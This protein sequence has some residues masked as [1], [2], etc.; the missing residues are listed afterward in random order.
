M[1]SVS[2]RPTRI[3]RGSRHQALRYSV[4]AACEYLEQRVLLS[5]V[6]WNTSASGSWDTAANWLATDTSTARVPTAGDNV[7]IN[8]AGVTVTISAGNAESMA[9]LSCADNLQITSGS[10]NITSNSEIDG[11]FGIGGSGV[12]MGGATLTVTGATEWDSAAVTSGTLKN[13]GTLTLGSGSDKALNGATLD[14]TGT[15]VHALGRLIPSNGII[16]NESGG[17]YDFQTDDG[18]VFN[19]GTDTFNNSGTLRKSVGTGTSFVGITFNNAAGAAIN[20]QTGTLSLTAGGT[21]LGGVYT[22][23][24]GAVFDPTGGTTNNFTGTYTGSGAGA[25]NLSSGTLNIAGGATFNF[26]A[27]F[28]QWTGGAIAGG[29]LNNT[30]SITLSGANDKALNGATIENTGTILHVAG[31]LIPSNG[32]INNHV[33]ATYDL[34]SAGG[35]IFNGGTDAFSNSG[36]L[37]KSAGTGNSAFTIVFNNVPGAQVNVL[38]GSISFNAGGTSTGGTFNVSANAVLDLTAGSTNNLTGTYTGSGAGTILLANGVLNIAGGATFNFASGYFQWTGGAI[39]GGT[40]VNANVLTLAS[41]ND[42]ALNGATLDN[43]GTVIHLMGRLIPS[44]GIIMNEAN[45]V[46]DFQNAADASITFNGG[47]DAFNNFGTLRKSSGAGNVTITIVFNNDAAGVIDDRNATTMTFSGGT[48]DAGAKF[49]LAS[50]A[51]IDPTGGGTTNW[52]GTYTS[53]GAGTIL[54]ANGTLNVGNAGATFNFPAGIFQWTGG[55]LTGGGGLL[56]KGI[57]TLN[58]TNDKALNGIVLNNAGTVLHLNGRLLP[59]NGTINN[60]SG[61]LYDLQS[62]GGII[63]NGGTDAFN[64][65][66]IFE[67]SAGTVSSAI[68]VTYNNVPGAQINVLT[69]GI[70]LAGSGSNTG[71]IFNLSAGTTLD[72]TGGNNNN[73][74]G[75]YTGSGAGTVQMASG[76]L[77]VTAGATFNLPARM[78][79]WTGGAIASGTLTNA[80][81]LTLS[82]INDK[83]LNGATLDNTGTIVHL[84]GRLLPSNGTVINEASGLYD[85]QG[86]NSIVFN[87]GTDVVT[88]SGILRKSLGTGTSQITVGVTNSGTIEVDSGTLSLASLTQASSGAIIVRVFN[89][90]GG[91]LSIQSPFALAGTLNVILPTGF[92]PPQGNTYNVVSY[93]SQTGAFSSVNGLTA[94]G[95][96]FTPSVGTTAVTL[97]TTTGSP[98]ASADLTLTSVS[99]NAGTYMAGDTLTLTGTEQNLGTGAAGNYDVEVALSTDQIFGDANNIVLKTIHEI[100]LA[101]EASRP[102]SVPLTIPTAATGGTYYLLAQIDSGQVINQT[103]YTNDLFVS[104]SPNVIVAVPPPPPPVSPPPPP[105]TSPPPAPV[106]TIGALDPTFGVNGLASH[107]VGLTSTAGVVV[108]S[109]GKSVIAGT[110]GTSPSQQFGVTRYNA[111]GSLDTSFGTNGV[112]TSSFGGSDVAS[113]VAY[114]PATGDI[115]VAGTD[116]TASGSRFVLA[117]Y[118]PAGVLDTTFNGTGFVLTSFSTTPGTMSHDTAKA[119]AV[120]SNGSTICVAGSS[121]AAGKGLDFA[122]ASYN[123][124]GS[125]NTRFGGSGMVTLDFA[126]GDDSINAIALQTNGDLV[127]AGSTTNPSN[128]IASIALARFL[129]TGAVDTRFGSKG[130]VVASGRGVAD[131]ASSVAIDRT[132]KIVIGGLSATGSASDGSL[133]SDFVVARYTSAGLLDR[134]FNGGTV[135][136]SFGQPSAVT[137]VLIQGDG[138]IVASGKTVASLTGLDPS[139]LNIA[140]ARYTSA[141]KLDT[142]FNS[143]G[144]AIIGLNGTS[145]TPQA[146]RLAR[147]SASVQPSFIASFKLTQFSITPQDT[148]SSLLAEFNQFQQSS[149]GVVAVTQGG[150]LLDVGNSGANTVEAALVTA[151]IDL[152]AT[153]VAKLPTAALEGA[154]GSLTVKITESGTNAA[155]GTVTIQLFASP[156]GFVDAG[157][158]PFASFPERIINLRQNQSRTFPLRYALPASAGTF[159]V[160]ANVDTGSLAEL[161][162]NNN[163]AASSTAVQVASPFVDLAGSGLTSVGTPAA[164]KFTTI[165]FTVTNNGNILAHSVPVQ[166]L[167]SPDGTVVIGSPLA[168]PTLLLNLPPGVSRKYH[169]TFRVPTTLAANTYVLVAVLDPGNTLSDPTQAD[170]VIVGTTQFTVH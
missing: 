158:T 8:R 142:T 37:E 85:I 151:G 159:F 133:S 114:L 110:A 72:L 75:T 46:Y 97:T 56:N 134:T 132:G 61:G 13:T 136:T 100:G 153:L 41:S 120:A 148:A 117:E 31:R 94:A 71:G 91:Q 48:N 144:M 60:Q 42:K 155:S 20:V 73:F 122:V 58:G 7:V 47:T 43:I 135:I 66:G 45:G 2:H 116:T 76:V 163:A 102:L 29:T 10:L 137:Q 82:G 118:T 143:T 88:N 92:V 70:A 30:A 80:G 89:Q 127:A 96:A 104:A 170:N 165:S 160:V 125:A 81:V 86:D 52:S 161:N 79:Q 168:Q 166:V 12:N 17:T 167:A 1:Q 138:K 54:L 84:N 123:A 157:L 162:A 51:V 49:L 63:F 99:Y 64:N 164:G 16:T 90:G 150:Q 38:T 139:Q 113:A 23:A 103:N 119:L 149:Q 21:S 57:L 107:N 121:D 147:A 50:G 115:L 68:T 27:G 108:Q 24:A 59:S 35:I 169:M 44:N 74:T 39:S 32:T 140:L 5:T 87:G 130:K 105:P 18:I 25:V 33:G 15:V 62:A 55:A 19:G 128:G 28:F 145:A 36:V 83:A 4:R 111:D 22:V 53:T 93:P 77:S 14:N 106:K 101:G 124:D 95:V 154:K 146:A 6:Q 26:P 129:P 152:A 65:T 40:L 69:G 34:Q 9:S 98:P 67:K 156:D 112:V 11:S 78:F 141:G 3:Q 109:D 126:G 131:I